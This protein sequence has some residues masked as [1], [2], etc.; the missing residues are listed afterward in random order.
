MF[1]K[2]Q[3]RQTMCHR[4]AFWK[5]ITLPKLEAMGRVEIPNLK[6]PRDLA[7]WMVLVETKR[8]SKSGYENV[9]V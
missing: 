3:K 7:F 1:Y 9:C 2:E 8:G 4:P 6:K 5:K